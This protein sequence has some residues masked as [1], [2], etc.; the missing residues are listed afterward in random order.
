MNL[1]KFATKG[2]LGAAAAV[3]VVAG[4]LYAIDRWAEAQI[5]AKKP[6]V[7]PTAPPPTT[8]A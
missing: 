8:T 3:G 4:G 7:P 1:L 6:V 2:L 5:A